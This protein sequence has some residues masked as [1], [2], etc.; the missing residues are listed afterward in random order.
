MDQ[1]A[2]EDES[3][4][5]DKLMSIDELAESGEL[6]EEEIKVLREVDDVLAT[7]PH[8]MDGCY[9]LMLECEKAGFE[10]KPIKSSVLKREFPEMPFTTE[11]W[12]EWV[13]KRRQSVIQ[14]CL[15]LMECFSKYFSY[16]NFS[17]TLWSQK[18][19]DQL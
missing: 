7:K 1:S 8:L 17:G 12:Q 18:N 14:H 3:S 16:S 6:N 9:H 4:N 11:K 13:S 15:S 19:V 10:P 2:E 5:W